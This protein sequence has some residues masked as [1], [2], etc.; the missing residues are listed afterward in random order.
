[1]LQNTRVLVLP[2]ALYC[3]LVL[4]L[5]NTLYCVLVLIYQIL[6]VMSL[7]S[8]YKIPC[9]VP[10]CS[11][12]KSSPTNLKHNY[13]KITPLYTFAAFKPQYKQTTVCASEV[14]YL[15]VPFVGQRRARLFSRCQ[16]IAK[17][18][19]VKARAL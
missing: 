8:Y 19:K 18:V 3:V 10:L 11:I 15:R 4:V 17:K 9:F 13:L 1:M 14:C 6:C 2:N 7:C 12:A 16:L 5:Q